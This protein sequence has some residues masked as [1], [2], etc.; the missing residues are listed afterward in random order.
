MGARALPDGE[1]EAA[2]EAANQASAA[3]WLAAMRAGDFEAAWRQ[4]DAIRRRGL[5][6]EHRFWQGQ[7]LRGKDVIV[8]CLHGF[9]D[10]VQMLRYAPRLREL[11]RR[12]SFEVPPQLLE[13]APCF[14]EVEHVVTWGDGAPA[15]PVP[16]DVQVEVMELPYV[17]RTT[18]AELPVATE[19]L[20]LPLA[21][22]DEAAAKMG[23]APGKRAGLVWA[24]GEWNPSRSLPAALLEPLLTQA[25]W[26]FWSLQ[27]GAQRGEL[28]GP[29]R[30]QTAVTGDGIAAL[31]A[32]IA[33][34]DLIITVD[35]LAAHLA[36]ALG[37]PCFV[38]L[39]Q[40]AD[41]RWIENRADSP[42]YPSLQ[43]FCQ[44]SSG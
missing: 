12:V 41:W 6:D 20:K 26:E 17:L 4:S 43:L 22:V 10:A 31:A 42:W 44:P 2:L 14:A 37:K 16:W 24:A 23:R 28:R 7:D 3:G 21:W 13:L 15:Q 35:T 38:L 25:R 40:E 36:G 19:Y 18:L 33:N 27:G 9:G 5:P 1:A 39:E 32:T 29:V 8:R 30:D 11:A 34:L